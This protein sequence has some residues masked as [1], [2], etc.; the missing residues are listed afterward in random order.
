MPTPAARRWSKLI[1]EQEASGQSIRVFAAS[2]GVNARTL[3]WWR[4][5]LKRERQAE[6][7]EF[8][9]AAPSAPPVLVE[10]ERYGARLPVTES[11]DLALLRKT[12]ESLC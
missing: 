8:R 7:V 9:V 5:K 6:F 2:R 1:E 3:G 12:L 11:T 10:L 4:S